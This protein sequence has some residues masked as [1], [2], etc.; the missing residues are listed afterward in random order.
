MPQLADLTQRQI[1]HGAPEAMCFVR[2]FTAAQ[3]SAAAWVKPVPTTRC[4]IAVNL[5]NCFWTSFLGVTV[6]MLLELL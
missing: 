2:S 5:R 6:G 1:G 4:F 3:T